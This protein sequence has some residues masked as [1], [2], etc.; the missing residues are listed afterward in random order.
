VQPE[1]GT[2]SVGPSGDGTFELQPS[3]APMTPQ[4]VYEDQKM[5]SGLF[6]VIHTVA[7][8]ILLSSCAIYISGKNKIETTLQP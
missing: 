7:N 2:N 8:T 4:D 5:K 6:L 1:N 3:P